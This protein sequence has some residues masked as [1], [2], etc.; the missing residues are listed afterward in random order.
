M[1]GAQ[2]RPQPGAAVKFTYSSGQKP[3]AGYT[4]KHCIGKGAFGEVYFG[5]SDGGKEVA[6]K[7][8]RDNLDIE[9][10]GGAQC[11]NLKHPNLVHLYDLRTDAAGEHWLVMEYVEG[12]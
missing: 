1:L 11:L 10:R 5:L 12:D 7:L 9:L 4:I 2:L 3:L 6:L 8:I